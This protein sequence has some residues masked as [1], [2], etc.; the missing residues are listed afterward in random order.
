MSHHHAGMIIEDGT[1]DSLDGAVG[2]SDF[3]AVHKVADPQLVDV[4]QFIGFSHICAG[5]DCQPLI[6]FDHPK[7]GVVVNGGFTQQPLIPEVLVELLYCPVGI[8]LAFDLDSFQCLLVKPF[9]SAT[10]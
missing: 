4:V 9:W 5:L 7:E 8:G 2:R 3:W 1:E 10:V 6:L